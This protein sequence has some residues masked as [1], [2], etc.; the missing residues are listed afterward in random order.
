M[1]IDSARFMVLIAF[2]G[3]MV[4]TLFRIALTLDLILKALAK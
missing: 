1:G 3:L 2:M 4:G